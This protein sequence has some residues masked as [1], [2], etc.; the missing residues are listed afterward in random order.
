MLIPFL[1]ILFFFLVKLT[2]KKAQQKIDVNKHIAFRL[3]VLVLFIALSFLVLYLLD[4]GNGI[5]GAVYLNIYFAVVWLLY[6]IV[7]TISLHV[8]KQTKLVQTNCIFLVCALFIP[9]IVTVQVL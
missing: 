6:I 3:G 5:I 7:E 2:I 1:I 8:V 9:A 4:G